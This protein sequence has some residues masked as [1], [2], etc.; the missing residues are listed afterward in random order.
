VLELPLRLFGARFPADRVW[1]HGHRACVHLL[2][3]TS[4]L[5]PPSCLSFSETVPSVEELCRQLDIIEIQALMTEGFA[6]A[7][8][9][10]YPQWRRFPL[11]SF[12]DGTGGGR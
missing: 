3:N 4:L 1:P 12:D 9:L 11:P 2:L 7:I 5:E 8:G 10:W 6:A